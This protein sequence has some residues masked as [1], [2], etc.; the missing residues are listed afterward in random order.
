MHI[1][2]NPLQ[3]PQGRAGRAGSVRMEAE[4]GEECVVVEQTKMEDEVRGRS[5]WCRRGVGALE[6]GLRLGRF[7]RHEA[8][9]AGTWRVQG[10]L[11]RRCRFRR[12]GGCL[13]NQIIDTAPLERAV[14][15]QDAR[16]QRRGALCRRRRQGPPHG[17][18]QRH[19]V[20]VKSRVDLIR[21]TW[22]TNQPVSRVTYVEVD[23]KAP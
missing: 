4:A 6:L 7:G 13:L 2:E 14:V 5:V 17:P 8:A 21:Y 12:I 16:T 9:A 23:A 3:V 1:I 22:G 20:N 10:G 19:L 15:C 11:R 18:G